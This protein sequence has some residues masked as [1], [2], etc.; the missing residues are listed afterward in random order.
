MERFERMELF[1]LLELL[2]P[3]EQFPNQVLTHQIR[4][5]HDPFSR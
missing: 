5:F 3:F 4:I 1:E 2:E